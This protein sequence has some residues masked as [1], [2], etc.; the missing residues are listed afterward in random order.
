M[1]LYSLQEAGNLP[2]SSVGRKAVNLSRLYTMGYRICRGVVLGAEALP[3]YC[4]ANGFSLE[5]AEPQRILAG[6]FPEDIALLLSEAYHRLRGEKREL[7]VRSSAGEEDGRERSFAGVFESCLHIQSLLQLEE[8]VK[9]VW[10][11]FI[12]PD[13]AAYRSGR[14][15]GGMAVI[16]QQMLSC[17]I[18]G[19]LFTRDPVNAQDRILWNIRRGIIRGLPAAAKGES[20]QG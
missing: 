12:A 4:E 17:E 15:N 3:R 18:S 20:L 19:V 6:K 10:A 8:A 1:R 5:T 14:P 16:F 7:I 9:R 13:A 2:L 11:S